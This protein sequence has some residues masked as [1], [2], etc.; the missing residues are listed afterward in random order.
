MIASNDCFSK[1]EE[2]PPKLAKPKIGLS[3]LSGL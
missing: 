2:L 1:Y 3:G